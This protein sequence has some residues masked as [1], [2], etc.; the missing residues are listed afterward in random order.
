VPDADLQPPNDVA[1]VRAALMQDLAPLAVVAEAV[2]KNI[3]T[4]QRLV[5]QGKLP[6]V[7]IGRT[8]YVVVSRARELLLAESKV[9][10]APIRRGRP[11]HKKAAA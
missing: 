10:H 5:V 2:G 4:I 11:T 8:P 9:R 3:R 6:T 1:A 7:T